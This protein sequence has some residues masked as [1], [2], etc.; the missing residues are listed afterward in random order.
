MALIHRAT[1]S[2]TKSEI[3]A[4]WLPAEQRTP[5]GYRAVADLFNRAG[6]QTAAAGIRFAYHNH[7]YEFAR[8]DGGMPYDLLLERCDPRY[9][10]FEMDL[11]WITK[12]GQDPLAYFARWPA[13][14]F[15][16]RTRIVRSRKRLSPRFCAPMPSPVYAS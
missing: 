12:G 16:M 3:I 10:A 1:L 9:V 11:Y 6:R 8:L 7:A 2:P 13:L 5:D 14:G 15:S 4:A